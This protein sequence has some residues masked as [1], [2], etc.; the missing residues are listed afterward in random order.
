MAFT[1]G[2][3]HRDS[4]S[5]SVSRWA[6][7]TIFAFAGLWDRWKNANGE[8]LESCS[9]LTTAAN[10]VTLDIHNRMPVIPHRD[11]HDLWLDPEM[12][13]LAAISELF[14]PFDVARMRRFP[15]SSRVN[16]VQNDDQSC[17]APFEP[18]PHPVQTFLL[19]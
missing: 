11:A 5:H 6:K 19:E 8:W 7:E 9:I 16:S 4:N 18:V 10:S 14:K 3:E 1:S 12:R 17:A 15:V 13:N 2:K